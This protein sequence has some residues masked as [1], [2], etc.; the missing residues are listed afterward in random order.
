MNMKFF[1]NESVKPCFVLLLLVLLIALPGC[2]ARKDNSSNKDLSVGSKL[3]YQK[4]GELPFMSET[5]ILATIDAQ[6]RPAGT[7]QG[8]K[9]GTGQ[10]TGGASAFQLVFG[11]RGNAVAYK[12]ERGGKQY[13]VINGAAGK[14]FNT[15]ESMVF[16]P[17]GRK[18]AYTGMDEQNIWHLVSD[19]R[20]DIMFNHIG[21]PVFSPD[22]RHIAFQ[23]SANEDWYIVVDNKQNMGGKNSYSQ[24][25][26]SADSSKLAYIEYSDDSSMKLYVSDLE[27]NIIR[28]IDRV[29]S[30]LARSRDGRKIA[31]VVNHNGK[32]KVVTMSFD[33]PDV[34]SEGVSYDSV[35][36]LVFSS[37]GESLA[38]IAAKGNDRY[39][40]FDGRETP[41]SA[42]SVKTLLINPD[43][44]SVGA[45]LVEKSGAVFRQ[46]FQGSI[47]EKRYDEVD[48]PVY[49]KD[50]TQH[51]YVARR[52]KSWFV[53]V[54]G[55][56]GALFDKVVSPGFSPDGNRFVYRAR[57]DGKRFVV[58]T[59]SKGQTLR[60]HPPYEQVLPP[61][62]NPD[63]QSVAYGV[64]DGDRLKWVVEKL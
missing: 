29:T 36:T 42:A 39:L 24:P 60:Q 4:S 54:N 7:F 47:S 23:A 59:D 8:H 26:F 61:V 12:V 13:A 16:S 11:D 45:V 10:P 51:A 63:G 1:S 52:G 21:E 53:V 22:S 48:V 27:F 15:V 57:K 5:R 50:G 55:A 6:D 30:P 31:V 56:E 46:Y 37:D 58:V 40:V 18:F 64:K 41:L 19:A 34:I 38:Y 3:M 9:G 33:R 49:S 62:F 44:K 28:I 17:D 2:D 25:V 20:A 32:Q 35:D 43:G 14:P